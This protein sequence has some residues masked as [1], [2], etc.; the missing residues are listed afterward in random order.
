MS[1]A[2]V[3]LYG[4]PDAELL[5]RSTGTVWS[6]EYRGEGGLKVIPAKLIASVVAMVPLQAGCFYV[7]EKLGLEVAC[8]GGAEDDEEDLTAE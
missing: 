5:E 2:L 7:V 1:F 4:A 3:S 8:M 6:C